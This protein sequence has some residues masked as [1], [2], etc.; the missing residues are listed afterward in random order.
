MAFLSTARAER[1]VRDLLRSADIEINGSRPWDVQV[2]DLRFYPRVIRHG[3]LG[4]GESYMDGWWTCEKLDEFFFRVCRARLHKRIPKTFEALWLTL[5]SI[6]FNRQT[7]RGSKVVAEQ[8]YDLGNDL[9]E[10]FLDPYNQYTCGYFKD[11]EDLNAAQEQK[12]DLI[13]RKLRLKSGDRVL[14]IGCGWGGFA[15]FAAERYGAHVTGVTISKEQAAY[16]REYCKG[17]PVE[18]RLQDYRDVKDTFDKV[19]ICGMI[20]HVGYKNYR[21]IMRVVHR[22]LTDDGIFLLHTIGSDVSVHAANAWTTKYI[23]PNSM[24]PSLRQLTSAFE[25]LFVMEDWHNFGWSYAKTTFAWHRNFVRNWPKVAARYG[26]RFY[27]MWEY[28][29][30]SGSGAFRARAMQLWQIVLTKHGIVGGYMAPR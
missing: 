13:C 18:I 22:C 9:Y 27:R 2:K 15:K 7:K 16:A 11:T 1:F 19:L 4:L 8:H 29:L 6:L 3:E 24:L 5:T 12:L 20:E 28:Y 10:S 26:D 21:E 23:F 17:L 30:L 14:D 25:G